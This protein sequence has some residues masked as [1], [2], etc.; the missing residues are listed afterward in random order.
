MLWNVG[1]H[2]NVKHNDHWLLAIL[3]CV[4]KFSFHLTEM[5]FPSQSPN[6]QTKIHSQV[7][8]TYYWTTQIMLVHFKNMLPCSMLGICIWECN[9]YAL[10]ARGMKI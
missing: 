9:I 6:T 7:T 4:H 10:N 8:Q 5:D 1:F 2:G 3:L